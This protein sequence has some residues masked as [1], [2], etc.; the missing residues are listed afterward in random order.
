MRS[1]PS[2]PVSGCA[3]LFLLAYQLVSFIFKYQK[4]QLEWLK[5]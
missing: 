3:A 5:Q 1:F 2:Q 4:L